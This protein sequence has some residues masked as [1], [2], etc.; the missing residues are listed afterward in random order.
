MTT[1]GQLLHDL[2]NQD[3]TSLEGS[4]EF[5]HAFF[6]KTLTIH[7][8]KK[9]FDVVSQSNI[10]VAGKTI[11]AAIHIPCGKPMPEGEMP[12]QILAQ[13]HGNEPAG[14]AGI[15]LAMALSQ[16]GLLKRDIIGLIGNPLASAQYFEAYLKHPH[17]R[18]ETRDAYRCGV[19][20]EGNLLPDM[21]R[22]PTDFMSRTPDTHHIKRAQEIYHASLH[23]CGIADIHTARGNMVCFTDHKYDGELKYSP[24]RSLLTG[25]ATAIAA[26]SSGTSNVQTWKSILANLPNLKSHTGIEAGRHEIPEAPFN[27]AS[28]TLSI[29]YTLGHSD[30]QPL[31]M[32]ETGIFQQYAVK[33]RITY[34]DLAH[35]GVLHGDD[36]I[37]MAKTC[38]A[39]ASVPERSDTVIVQK[40]DGQ[41]AL[42]PLAEFSVKPA[43]DLM[44]AIYQ[45]DEM[46]A[47]GK[48]EV[49]AVA[50]PSGIAFKTTEAFSGIFFSKSGALYDKDPAVGPWPVPAAKIASVKF[51]YP[52]H[53]SETKLIHD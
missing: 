40:P 2:F 34:A 1:I 46:E 4:K 23:V 18:Q 22:I 8:L 16:A 21:N 53:V 11:P 19:D 12:F 36:K 10:T 45:Y 51:C 6:K 33:P 50:I 17:A 5:H 3:F 7:D 48:D 9:I 49:A 31:D 32:E 47:L 38:R 37:Y 29:L 39:L 28:Y 35:H 20:D 24:I 43:G 27:A 14:L 41:F 13:T 30:A 42:Q 52:C 44:Y 25:L 15:A 26:Y